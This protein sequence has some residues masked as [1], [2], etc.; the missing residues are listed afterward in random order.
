MAAFGEV[1]VSI[2]VTVISSVVETAAS[3]GQK[4]LLLLQIVA[5]N[6]GRIPPLTLFIAAAI[7]AAVVFFLFR[8]FKTESKQ[9]IV[10]IF[11]LIALVVVALS[12][13][14]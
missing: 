5:S 8:M 11:I 13:L 12:L 3:I 10:A 4:V 1:L 14:R 2:V 9:L 7:F 6:A